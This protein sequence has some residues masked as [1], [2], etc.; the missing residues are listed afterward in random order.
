[1]LYQAIRDQHTFL[2]QYDLGQA[3]PYQIISYH[4]NPPSESK[5]PYIGRGR[6]DQGGQ[7]SLKVLLWFST[8][9]GSVRPRQHEE[10]TQSPEEN[11]KKKKALGAPT[12]SK[13]E[14]KRGA[15]CRNGKRATDGGI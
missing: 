6:R 15:S 11:R 4:L 9:F 8:D 5:I 13:K 2:L 10:S 14:K 7:R 12:K 1:M 3:Y